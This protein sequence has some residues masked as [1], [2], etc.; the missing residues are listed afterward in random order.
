MKHLPI[1]AFAILLTSCKTTQPVVLPQT[2]DSIVIRTELR[3]DSVYIDRYHT[4][5]IKGETI[6]IHDSF[7][8][9]RYKVLTKTDS[10][11]RID[12]IPYPVE[13]Q[14]VQE[15]VPAFYKNCTIA[16]WIFIALTFVAIV[17]RIIIKLK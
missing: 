13:V 17:L 14:V 1:I 4:E 8:D 7:V 2:H 9:Y 12:S 3:I 6:Y 16:L 10:I 11:V 5:Y 15:V